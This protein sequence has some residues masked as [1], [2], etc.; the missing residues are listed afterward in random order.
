MQLDIL[1][2][3]AHF[4]SKNL[5]QKFKLVEKSVRKF[6]SVKILAFPVRIDNISFTKAHAMY[7]INI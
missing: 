5:Q 7:L 4:D 1:L 2:S 3:G 6:E